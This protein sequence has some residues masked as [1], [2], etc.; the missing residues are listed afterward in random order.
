MKRINLLLKQAAGVPNKPLVKVGDRVKEGQQVGEI[1]N[2]SLGAVVHSPIDGVV[3]SV[4]S[5]KICI[6]K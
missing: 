5:E 2:G 1:P 4:D 6:E 3:V